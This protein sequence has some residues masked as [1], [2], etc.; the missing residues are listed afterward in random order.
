[1]HKT[2]FTLLLSAVALLC[3]AFRAGAQEIPGDTTQLVVV[4]T[5]D[6]NEFIGTLVAQDSAVVVLQT[7]NFGQIRIRR[8]VVRRIQAQPLTKR[9]NGTYWRKSPHTTR[10]FASS[11]AYGLP[12]GDGYYENG[13]LFYNQVTY[14]FSDHF[15]LGAGFAPLILLDGPFPVWL[16]PKISIPLRK[17][18]VNLAVGS[19]IGHSFSMYE[20][21]AGPFGAVYGQLTVGPRDA[22]LSAGFGYGIADQSWSRAPIFSLGGLIRTGSKLALLSESY[23]VEIDGERFNLFALGARFL[24]RRIAL[25]GALVL[26]VWEYEGAYPIPWVGLRVPFGTPAK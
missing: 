8:E 25:D 23:F 24:G 17:D 11:S 19:Y 2:L 16:A 5:I 21:E 9:A 14:G 6:G 4:Q 7:E 20:D 12:R 13:W 15:S 22:H 10:Y 26:A 3:F 18:R 1:M